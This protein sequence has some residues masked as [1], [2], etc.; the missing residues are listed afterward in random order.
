MSE[1]PHPRLERA[2][3]T[4]R[5]LLWA[6]AIS[7]LAVTSS[8]CATGPSADR[9]QFG[10]PSAL[11]HIASSDGDVALVTAAIADEE[12]LLGECA[13]AAAAHP[14][15]RS[16]VKPLQ[17]GLSVHVAVLRNALTVPAAHVRAT[18][19]PTAQSAEG[20]VRH[21]LGA[22]TRTEQRRRQDCLAA[23]SGPLARLL[24]SMAASHAVTVQRLK[25]AP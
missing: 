4:R 22:F 7:G 24:A 13:R 15:L 10:M 18:S 16:L 23:S 2:Q 19:G 17:S 20:A 5:D 11:V 8:A 21:L 9:T 14:P 3:L 25:P 12:R 6:A 1:A